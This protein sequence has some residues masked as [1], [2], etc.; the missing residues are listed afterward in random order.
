MKRG[1][2]LAELLITLG[3]IGIAA[4][5]IVPA[6]N[7]LRPDKNK[8]MYLQAYDT[9][10][11]TVQSL[12]SNSRLYP[13]CKDPDADDNVNCSENPLFNTNMPI[14]ERYRNANFSGEKKLC[15]LMGISMGISEDNLQCSDTAYAFNNQD[16]Q[17]GFANESFVTKNGMR[18]RIVPAIASSSDGM[19]ASYQTDI[20]VDV[21]PT[22]NDV[23]GKDRSCIYDGDEC[24]APDIFKFM[25]AANG[26]VQAADAVGQRYIRTRKNLLRAPLEIADGV[27]PVSNTVLDRNFQYSP[28]KE[29][30]EEDDGLGDEGDEDDDENVIELDRNK[31]ISCLNDVTYN[32][33]MTELCG[34]TLNRYS[35]SRSDNGITVTL[36]NPAAS[37]MTWRPDIQTQ[38]GPRKNIRYLSNLTCTINPGASSCTIPRDAICNAL[39][40]AMPN[41]DPNTIKDNL[42]F[43]NSSPSSSGSSYK[44]MS[45]FLSP[46]F[47]SKY[48]YYQTHIEE[49]LIYRIY[50]KIR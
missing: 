10:S 23:N 14:D 37:T 1:F 49:Y 47:D 27:T 43:T 31:I 18:W 42:Y 22:N 12:A 48:L 44:Q 39:I 21:D 9:V 38:W 17:N 33:G 36:T 8:M 24:E 28:C 7:S 6:A 50:T 15:S 46:K 40:Q 5:L 29:I 13:V 3:I 16:Y 11:E 41:V 45:D 25:V 34:L 30:I 26:T 32:F 19:N 20:Y 4:A 2:T 35:T